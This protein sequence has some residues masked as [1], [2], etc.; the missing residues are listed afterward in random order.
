MPKESFIAKEIYLANKL[1]SPDNL[2]YYE[3][4]NTLES[5]KGRFAPQKIKEAQVSLI[6]QMLYNIP[7]NKESQ[8][9]WNYI[10]DLSIKDDL[11]HDQI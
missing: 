5:L 11:T 4:Y 10:K 9:K 3:K 8:A 7:L 1:I 2:Y 6:N